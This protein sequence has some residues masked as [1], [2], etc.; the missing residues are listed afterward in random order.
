VL[1]KIFFTMRVFY[2]HKYYFFTFRLLKKFSNSH[3]IHPLDWQCIMDKYDK[4]WK[5]IIID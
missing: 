3:I 4:N 5:W 1:R 2:E